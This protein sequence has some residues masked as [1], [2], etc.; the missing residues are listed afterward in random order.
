MAESAPNGPQQAKMIDVEFDLG[1]LCIYNTAHVDYPEDPEAY[2]EKI[3]Q[4]ALDNY[5]KIFGRLLELREK[6]DVERDKKKLELQI[7]DFDKTEYHVVLPEITTLFP[8]FNPMPSKKEMTKWEKF[9]KDK[10]IKKDRRSKVF[11]EASQTWVNLR[12]S[13][14]IRKLN[15]KRDVARE[16]KQGQDIYSDPFEQEKETKR[17]AKQK[18]E[19]Q[20]IRNKLR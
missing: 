20:E 5:R 4:L 8:R 16:L 2:E 7:H 17:A 9:A 19:I 18:Q 14:S 10:G 12:G 13:K 1:S 11:D 6:E 3:Q 15:E